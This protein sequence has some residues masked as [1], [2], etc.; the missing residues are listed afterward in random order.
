[1]ITKSTLSTTDSETNSD[2][3]VHSVND[4][5][6]CVFYNILVV[7]RLVRGRASL[8][9]CVL[10]VLASGKDSH[11]RG[12]NRSSSLYSSVVERQSCKLE[13]R[14]SILREKD[15]TMTSSCLMSRRRV[16]DYVFHEQCVEGMFFSPLLPSRWQNWHSCLIHSMTLVREEKERSLITY[17]E[18]YHCYSKF[19]CLCFYQMMH[20]EN[21]S[22]MQSTNQWRRR[23]Q[24][25]ISLTHKHSVRP[26]RRWCLASTNLNY[27]GPLTQRMQYC[28]DFHSQSDDF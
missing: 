2:I 27:C 15:S 17:F 22:R 12:K 3:S 1:M 14:S 13:V 18:K 25:R 8:L 24:D 21:H 5:H 16:I 10:T 4:L 9:M 26:M 7:Y 20:R 28:S 19:I 23:G 11:Q 6:P